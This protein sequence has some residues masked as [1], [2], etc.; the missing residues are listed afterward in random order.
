MDQG[1]RKRKERSGDLLEERTDE[2]D[3]FLYDCRPASL[4]NIIRLL[5]KRQRKESSGDLLEERADEFEQF[6]Y[7]CPFASFANLAR[8]LPWTEG[9]L[10]YWF[11]E[12]NVVL[13]HKLSEE[14]LQV[15]QK[16]HNEER[17]VEESCSSII[18]GF[19]GDEIALPV[20]KRHG[21]YKKKRWAPIVFNIGTT[22]NKRKKKKTATDLSK[23]VAEPQGE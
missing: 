22:E 5:G 16:L 9:K 6:L 18:Y 7:D 23:A 20:G 4:V 8:Y 15:I 21:K 19:D 12:N 14:G 10:L 17:I 3:Q 13:W 2:F 1:K 11:P